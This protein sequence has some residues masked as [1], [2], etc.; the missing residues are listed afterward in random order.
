[1][2]QLLKIISDVPKSQLHRSELRKSGVS[3]TNRQDNLSYREFLEA[4]VEK[5][6]LTLIFYKGNGK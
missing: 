2:W 4:C 5:Y 3:Y 6:M 1:M